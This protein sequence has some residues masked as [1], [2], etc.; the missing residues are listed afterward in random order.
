MI[1]NTDI[2][3]NNIPDG[4][5]PLPVTSLQSGFFILAGIMPSSF[6]KPG[7]AVQLLKTYA[8]HDYHEWH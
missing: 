3:R 1:V 8:I 2:N 6:S 7:L 5:P 4:V